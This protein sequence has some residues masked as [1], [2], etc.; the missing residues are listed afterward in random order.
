M[1]QV[2]DNLHL[3]ERH[4]QAAT[5]IKGYWEARAPSPWKKI[6][7]PLNRMQVAHRGSTQGAVHVRDSGGSLRFDDELPK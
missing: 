7:L 3:L 4:L 5:S 2:S 6:H 1:V